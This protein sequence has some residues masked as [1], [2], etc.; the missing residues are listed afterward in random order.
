MLFAYN[1]LSCIVHK[2]LDLEGSLKL[3]KFTKKHAERHSGP[4]R[5]FL[6]HVV[7]MLFA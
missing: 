1:A 4:Q 2:F 5:K 7:Q 3:Q 6:S